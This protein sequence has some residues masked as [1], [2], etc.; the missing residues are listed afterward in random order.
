MT[1]VLPC[2]VNGPRKFPAFRRG[3]IAL[4]NACLRCGCAGWKIG[5][6]LQHLWSGERDEAVLTGLVDELDPNSRALVVR[7]LEYAHAIEAEHGPP[8]RILE[9]ESAD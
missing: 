3:W 1:P 6:A 5:S 9:R 7:I 4:P 8:V 2:L